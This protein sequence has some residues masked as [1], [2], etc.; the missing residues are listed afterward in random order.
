MSHDGVDPE[1]VEVINRRMDVLSALSTAREKRDLVDELDL[2]RSTVNRAVRQLE[3]LGLVTRR[4]GYRQTVA[5]RLVHDVYDEFVEEL[6][7]VVRMEGLLT[8]MPPDQ[9]MD[10][11]MVRGA[12]VHRPSA[13]APTA[14]LERS[15]ELLRDAEHLKALTPRVSRADLFEV[16]R[17]EAHDGLG[18]EMVLSRELLDHVREHR[19]DWLAAMTAAEGAELFVRADLTLN[20][21]AARLPGGQRAAMSV[22]D[23]AG[24]FQGL[25]ENGSLEAYAWAEGVFADVRAAA[26]PLDG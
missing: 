1:L 14:T 18:L 20:L 22:Y 11:A 17:E 25:V 10:L 6:A 26:E 7:A 19:P 15:A 12:T 5:G 8:A 16:V 24:E 13:A 9:P 21:G 3:S 4:E 23:P 2:S